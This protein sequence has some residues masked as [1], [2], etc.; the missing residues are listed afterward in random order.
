MGRA[1]TDAELVAVRVAIIAW[2]GPM[3]DPT[4]RLASNPDYVQDDEVD[5]LVR[6]IRLALEVA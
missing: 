2:L 3:Y 1:L 6:H 4:G 5:D